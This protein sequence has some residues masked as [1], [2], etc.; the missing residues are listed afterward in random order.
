MNKL[1]LRESLDRYEKSDFLGLYQIAE[2]LGIDRG[3]ARHMMCGLPYIP[4]GRKKLYYKADIIERLMELREN[5]NEKITE[6]D[7]T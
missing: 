7:C 3:T 1:E 6:R 5:R 2:V 4:C